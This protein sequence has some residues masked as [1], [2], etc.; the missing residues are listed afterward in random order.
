V[1]DDT[2]REIEQRCKAASAGPWRQANAESRYVQT[3]DD[4]QGIYSIRVSPTR[5]LADATFIAHARTDTPLLLAEVRRLRAALAE[6]GEAAG[7]V[8]AARESDVRLL[9]TLRPPIAGTV[10]W[11]SPGAESALADVALKATG[12]AQ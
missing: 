9:A 5:R 11:A 7:R 2:L 3:P 12:E 1:T 6:I 4:E 8:R 10:G